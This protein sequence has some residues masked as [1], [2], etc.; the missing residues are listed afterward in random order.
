MKFCLFIASKSVKILT[1]FK[2][3]VPPMAYF[4]VV[5]I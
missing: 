2:I 5:D 3:D 4:K 1:S